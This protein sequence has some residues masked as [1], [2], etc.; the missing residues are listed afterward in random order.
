MSLSLY[1]AAITGRDY[2][3]HNG[4]KTP[5]WDLLDNQPS[6]WLTS[7]VNIKA[8]LPSGSLKMFDCGAWTYRDEEIPILKGREVTPE[9]AYD[10]YKK[11]CNAG[12]FLIAPDHMLLPDKDNEHRGI[13]NYKNAMRFIEICDPTYRPVVCIHGITVDDKVANFI[14]MKK[15]GYSNFALGGLAA[16][17]IN[18][19]YCIDSVRRVI[20]VAEKGDWVHVLGLSSVYFARAWAAMG[21]SSF[22]GASHFLRALTAGYFYK[23]DGKHLIA[24]RPGEKTDI[25]QCVCKSC[26]TINDLGGYSVLW[27]LIKQYRPCRT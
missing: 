10:E 23:N 1:F 5:F 20:E 15:L 7:I 6:G 12:D 19:Q 11:H 26:R 17:A 25:P 4:K 9:Y 22:D 16:R 21:V 14:R 18:R 24:A 2:I 8:G 3:K 27:E 13:I